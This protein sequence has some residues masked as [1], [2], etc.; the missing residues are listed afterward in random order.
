M[1][2]RQLRGG[3]ISLNNRFLCCPRECETQSN[4]IVIVDVLVSFGEHAEKYAPLLIVQY[5]KIVGRSLQGKFGLVDN[6]QSADIPQFD[7]VRE[8]LIIVVGLCLITIIECD[9]DKLIFDNRVAYEFLLRNLMHEYLVLCFILFGL[10][11]AILGHWRIGIEPAQTLQLECG[12]IQST[13]IIL[14]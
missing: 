8:L 11:L 14:R 2:V 13:N 9:S 10:L 1:I 5:P 7:G 3:L 12:S 6:L 4:A